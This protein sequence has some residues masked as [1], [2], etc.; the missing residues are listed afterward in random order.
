MTTAVLDSVDALQAQAE[1]Y[2]GAAWL[3]LVNQFAD[4]ELPAPADVARVFRDTGKD[5]KDLERDGAVV[6]EYRRLEEQL[7]TVPKLQEEADELG[8]QVSSALREREEAE[9]ALKRAQE[10]LSRTDSAHN[11]ASNFLRIA[12][13]VEQRMT[14]PRFNL[15]KGAEPMTV[16]AQQLTEQIAAVEGKLEGLATRIHESERNLSRHEAELEAVDH[17]DD[18]TDVKNVHRTKIQGSID[19][20]TNRIHRYGDEQHALQRDLRVLRKELAAENSQLK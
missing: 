7:A 4:N 2:R 3:E 15:L 10:K 20:T 8:R 12:R 18:T 17:S 14:D 6:R 11:V 16:R 9:A 13:S 1:Y 5:R 19:G